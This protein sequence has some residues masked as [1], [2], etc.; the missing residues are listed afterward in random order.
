MPLT[1]IVHILNEEPVV[2]ELEELPDPQDQILICINPRLRDGR[3]VPYV[4]QE[5]RSLVY[6][7]H[8]IQCVE[9]LPGA[10]EEKVVTIVRE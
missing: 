5:V 9:I 3:D 1:V 8:R 2:A 7:W 6:P 4:L 10:E